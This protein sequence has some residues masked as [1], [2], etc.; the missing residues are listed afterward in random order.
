MPDVE[1][2]FKCV[3]Y[4]LPIDGDSSVCFLSSS[5]VLFEPNSNEYFDFCAK[6]KSS[7]GEV[8][9]CGVMNEDTASVWIGTGGLG[10]LDPGDSLFLELESPAFELISSSSVVPE[11]AVIVSYSMTSRSYFNGE[12]YFDELVLELSDPSPR[13]EAYMIQLISQVDTIG[14]HSPS[15]RSL[16]S[17]NPRMI[18]RKFGLTALDNALFFDDTFWEGGNYTFHFRTSNIVDEGVP[19]HFTLLIHSISIDMYQFFYDLEASDLTGYF[20]GGSFVVRSNVDGAHGCFGTMQTTP[21]L[22]FP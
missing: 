15:I 11:K 4:F 6:V 2:E 5:M 20:H 9:S 10:G 12:K 21:V 13:E 3:S 1:E 7:D 22:V 14:A 16:K 19:Y 17:D 18:R 8:T